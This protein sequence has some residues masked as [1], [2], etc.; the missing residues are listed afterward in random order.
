MVMADLIDPHGTVAICDPARGVGGAGRRRRLRGGTPPAPRPAGRPAPSRQLHVVHV[1]HVVQLY[2]R[3]WYTPADAVALFKTLDRLD[4][5]VRAVYAA[6]GLMID[7]VFPAA[8]GLPFA[9]LLV[10]LFR[11][12]FFLLPLATAAAD[13]LENATVAVLALGCTGAPSP[14]AWLPRRSPWSRRCS[15]APGWRRPASAMS[16]GCGCGCAGA[17]GPAARAD[18]RRS[19]GPRC[20]RSA[21]PARLRGPRRASSRAVLATMMYAARINETPPCGG[22]APSKRPAGRAGA[23]CPSPCA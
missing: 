23:P 22:R 6:T 9:I 4:A 8:Y 5:N 11:A 20:P 14:L 19:P 21:G 13:V 17:D 18:R 16:A 3:T 7:M 12:P 10:R 1:V 15:A 2:N